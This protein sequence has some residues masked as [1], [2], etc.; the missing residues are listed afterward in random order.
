MKRTQEKTQS[1]SFGN[2]VLKISKN[3]LNKGENAFWISTKFSKKAV[4]RNKLRR[5]LREIFRKKT[6]EEARKWDVLIIIKNNKKKLPNTEALKIDLKKT[7]EK[8]RVLFEKD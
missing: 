3:R 1:C 5:Q 6:G 4:E 7:L 2:I 8:T